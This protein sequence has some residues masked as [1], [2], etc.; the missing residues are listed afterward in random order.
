VRRYSF[1]KI[2]RSLF[3]KPK[4]E[5]P[6]PPPRKVPLALK[7]AVPAAL[8]ITALGVWMF[9]GEARKAFHSTSPGAQVPGLFTLEEQ[10]DVFARYAGSASCREC[11]EEAYQLW[12]TSNHGMAERIPLPHLED[13][14]FVPPRS[15]EHG[16]QETDV[17]KE[18]EH[19]EVRT[20]GLGGTNGPFV[21]DRV[22]GNNPLRQFLTPFPGGRWQ[23]LE[24]SWDPRSN[25]WFNVYGQEDRR[26]GEWG[27][28]TGRGMNWNS[29]CAVCHNTRLRKNYDV[30]TD[31]FQ[32]AMAERTVGC[33]ACHGPMK[34]HV[35]W[36]KRFGDKV[37]DPTIRKLNREQMFHT[38][39]SCHSR[40]TEL[41]GDF[42][43]GENY[44]DH[45]LLGIVDRS[46]TWY[47]D[48]QNWDEDYEYT[49]FLGSRMHN[50]G[51][52]CVDCHDFHS[53]K[54]RM[55][56]NWMC[57]TCHAVG[58]TNAIQID[59]V[60]H[61]FH[62][63]TNSGN[64]CT[65]CHMP[66]TPYMQRHWRH[67][68]GFTIPDPMLTKEFGIPNACNRCHQD[69]S[70]DWSIKHVGEWYGDKMDR[71]YRQRARVIAR[72]KE[73]NESAVDPLLRMLATDEIAYWR[74][75]AAGMLDP[76]L[77]QPRVIGGLLAQLADTNALVRMNV[78]R[79]LSPL[80]GAGNQAV[81]AAVQAALDDPRRGVR[82]QAASALRAEV[83]TNST[84]GSEPDAV[85]GVLPGTGRQWRCTEALWNG[86]LVGSLFTCAAP[87]LRRGAEHDRAY[88]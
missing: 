68:H 16:S 4:Q 34:D 88:T 53:A 67:D 58:T 8:L 14:A 73:A 79:T 1:Q 13:P 25:E 30:S 22:I 59:P 62:S 54:V 70:V 57:L 10:A 41:T 49:A 48:G 42:H 44:F 32:T 6:T 46:D 56:G 5:P 33:E 12:R 81:H 47:P 52:R 63:A 28:W 66:Q 72:A 38:C 55:P 3:V 78:I 45:Y 60:K 2:I 65:G 64:L 76:W 20:P 43:P 15:F 23:T 75:V 69:K 9:R 11:H 37:A 82:F 84:A 40:R 80:V 31:T 39:A 29:M 7:L 83:S 77:D 26:P 71:P 61:S 36:Q 86:C 74:A 24:A 17:W 85:G 19:Y 35:A 50:K 21:V 51:V 87:R 18:G 27:H